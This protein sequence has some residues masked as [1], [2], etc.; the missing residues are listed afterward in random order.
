MN[1]LKVMLLGLAIMGQL[2][3]L[4]ASRIKDIASVAGIVQTNLSAMA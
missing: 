4:Q 3:P 1:F 2:V